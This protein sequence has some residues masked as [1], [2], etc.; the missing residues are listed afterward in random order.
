MRAAADKEESG[1]V[2]KSLW[3]ESS[4]DTHTQPVARYLLATAGQGCNI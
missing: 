1:G 3:T 2:G 4:L